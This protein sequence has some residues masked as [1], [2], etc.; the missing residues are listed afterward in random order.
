MAKYK[1]M[2]DFSYHTKVIFCPERAI[3]QER[4]EANRDLKMTVERLAVTH[5][6]QAVLHHLSFAKKFAEE[7]N[8][9]HG[10]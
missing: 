10:K 7:F 8:A 9:N 6:P 2:N 1:G 5:G 4:L 3:E